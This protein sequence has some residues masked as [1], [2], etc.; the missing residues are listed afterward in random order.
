M[1]DVKLFIDGKWRDG[2][3]DQTIALVNPANGEPAGSVA[4][5]TTEDMNEAAAAAAAGF[6]L[7]RQ[8]SPVERDNVLRRAAKLLRERMESIAPVL[9]QQQGKTLAEARYEVNASAESLE[10]FAEEARRAYGRIVPA[11]AGKVYQLVFREPVGPVVGFVPWNFGMGQAARKVGPALAAGCSIIL[12]GPEETPS[13]CAYL[14]EALVDA[15]LPQGVIN[16]VF[17]IPS[18]ISEHLIAHP[19]IRKVSFTGST[20]V[21]KQLAALA[22]RHMKRITMELGGHAPVIVTSDVDVDKVADM[23]VGAKYRNA[24]QVCTAPTRF[25]LEEQVYEP[26]VEAF[27]RKTALLTVTEG[28]AEG[29]QMGPLANARRVQAMEALIADA[30]E[31]G[32][33]VVQGGHRI[34]NIGNFFEPTVMTEVPLGARAMNEEPFGPLAMMR[35]FADL[36]EALV[37]A[38]RLEYGLAAYAFTNSNT[39]AIRIASEV[40]S[41]MVSIN[42]FGLAFAEVPFGGIKESGYGSEG[43][44]EAIEPFLSTKLVSHAAL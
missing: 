12:K 13:C 24:G 32:G 1:M 26:F 17:G 3:G 35:P 44:S 2:V 22:G 23:L 14:V 19:V 31:R 11:R 5:A 16:L 39:A 40:E 28:T 10:W 33:K 18:E 4:V 43:G 8:T 36:D 29:A 21:G 20:A 7:W 6:A 42:N 30:V 9:T 27:S 38:N 41:G 15:G 34:G 25:L 37:E